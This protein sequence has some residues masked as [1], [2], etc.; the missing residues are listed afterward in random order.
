MILIF[1]EQKINNRSNRKYNNR[2]YTFEK[3]LKTN[4]L[5]SLATKTP[6]N[7]QIQTNEKSTLEKMNETKKKR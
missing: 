1:T 3:P 7:K 4:I 2:N 6:I 5:S